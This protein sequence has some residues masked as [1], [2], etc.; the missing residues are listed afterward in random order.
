MK[1]CTYTV[2]EVVPADMEATSP[3][4]LN[5]PITT[6]QNVTDK[7]FNNANT[8]GKLDGYKFK[9]MNEN[10]V[11]DAGEVGILGVRITLDGNKG[12]AVTN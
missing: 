12:E 9:D 4:T 10:G 3:T 11:M 6:G 5:V 2:S 8:K 1:A 7:D